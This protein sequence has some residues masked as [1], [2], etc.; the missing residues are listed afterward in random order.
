[1]DYF[2]DL[3]Q[4]EHR[5]KNCNHEVREGAAEDGRD[6]L[7]AMSAMNNDYFASSATARESRC[8]EDLGLGAQVGERDLVL[9]LL[10][11]NGAGIPGGHFTERGP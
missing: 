8:A 10:Q 5:R 9:A 7:D 11:S 4:R 3:A 6:T 2:A 1:L